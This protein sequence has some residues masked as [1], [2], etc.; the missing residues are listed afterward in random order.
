[1]SAKSD[2]PEKE[3]R[4]YEEQQEQLKQYHQKK[5]NSITWLLRQMWDLSN[6]K[7][8]S[9]ADI[10]VVVMVVVVCRSV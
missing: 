9:E 7:D 6:V 8:K 10:K 2:I 3:R 5:L 4:H 1:M